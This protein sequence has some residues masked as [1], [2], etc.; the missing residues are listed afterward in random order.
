MVTNIRI[1]TGKIFSGKVSTGM[2]LKVLDLEG[3]VI[4]EG[5][6]PKNSFSFFS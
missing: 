6:F 2:K 5:T 3:N 1:L 4:E